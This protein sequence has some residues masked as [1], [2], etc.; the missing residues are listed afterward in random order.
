MQKL[1]S[2]FIADALKDISDDPFEVMRLELTFKIL[3]FWIPVSLLPIIP[4]IIEEYWYMISSPLV[5]TIG[6][7]IALYS[8][9][10]TN[11][12]VLPSRIM[13]ATCLIGLFIMH[14]IGGGLLR[15]IDVLWIVLASILSFILL[16]RKLGLY[17]FMIN[18]IL[19][20]WSTL[21]FLGFI[22]SHQID[23]FEPYQSLFIN[24]NIISAIVPLFTIGYTLY[25]F[26]KAQEKAQKLL[27][28][29]KLDL[30]K[31]RKE[32]EIVQKETEDSI[33]Y[34][35]RIQ[36]AILTPSRVIKK[37]LD[38]SFVLYKP[39]D[40]VSGDFYWVQ[41]LND[42]VFFAVADCTGHGVPGA[43]V[44]V[45]C[46]NALNRAIKEFDLIDPAE[47][48]DKT[49]ILIINKFNKGSEEIKD[50]MDISLCA[51]NTKNNTL[52]WAGANNPL[53]II[54]NQ[55][56]NIEITAPNKQPVGEHSFKEPFISH[57]I[58]LYKNDMI[59]IATDGFV[60]QFGGIQ[61]KKY[62][63]AQLKKKLI[64][65]SEKPINLQHELLNLE[66]EK[67]K[68][69]LAQLDDVCI[70]GVRV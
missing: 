30:R 58:Q 6:S 29:Q 34:A 44:S 3:I 1:Q 38:K 54:R 43:M 35:K 27:S 39:K 9:K 13:I 55:T 51:L 42:I 11:S 46:T 53:W 28:L 48:L 56:K 16:G 26:L 65:L 32:V 49:R 52:C 47:I 15:G 69:D 68:G 22:P 12:Y 20:I 40:I 25:T 70:M 67:W 21:I 57:D 23:I 41:K 8:L 33:Y 7:S 24:P 19:I 36:S 59:Y 66:F 62:K 17:F 5:T 14:I 37:S 4:L 63:R 18:S 64:E 50:G 60:D 45:I 61:G 10:K 2:Y 31:K